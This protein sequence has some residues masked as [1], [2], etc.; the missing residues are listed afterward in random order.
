MAERGRVRLALDDYPWQGEVWLDL[1][2]SPVRVRST[3]PSVTR[4]LAELSASL[5]ARASE[6]DARRELTFHEETVLGA[7]RYA[8][9]V[10]GVR[11]VDTPASS[12]AFAQLMFDLNQV[13]IDAA[14]QPAL[15]H[16]AAA[17]APAGAVLLPGGMGA[18]KSTLVAGLVQ[19]GLRYLTDE[20]VAIDKDGTVRPY[21]KHLSL[22]ER[23]SPVLADLDA[24]VPNDPDGLLG[25]RRLVPPSCLRGGGVGPA[26]APRL[27]VLPEFAPGADPRLEPLPAPEALF[28][29]AAHTFRLDREPARSL[30]T[31]ESV[32]AGCACFRL[33]SGDLDRACELVLGLLEPLGART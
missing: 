20:V 2:G 15:V 30:A 21:P 27:V 8:V 14:E 16:A 6:G 11:S 13:A 23:T 4:L 28:A 5:V 32:A 26:M 1:L 31:L 24:C 19:R 22:G 29:L 10:D 18:G 3:V 7:I 17:G 25:G 12:V 9:T 33:V